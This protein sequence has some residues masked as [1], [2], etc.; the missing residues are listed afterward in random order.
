MRLQ[1]VISNASLNPQ[2][3]VYASVWEYIQA[4]TLLLVFVAL[5]MRNPAIVLSC[6]PFQKVF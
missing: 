6:H 2:Q 3:S 5:E 4:L 1:K